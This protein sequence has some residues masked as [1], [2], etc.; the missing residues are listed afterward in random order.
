MKRQLKNRP[1][2]CFQTIV[3]S[4]V[5]NNLFEKELVRLKVIVIIEIP[6]LKRKDSA[7]TKIR[8]GFKVF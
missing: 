8:H 6:A 2:S 3:L 4:L 7:V 1:R 5:Q